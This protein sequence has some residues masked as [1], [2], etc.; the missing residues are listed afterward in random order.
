MKIDP[1]RHKEKYLAWKERVKDGIPEISLENTQI[2]LQYL[3][4]MERGVNIASESSKGS[5]SF[6]RLNTL[7][8]KLLFFSKKFKEIYNLEKIID[9]TEEQVV[10]FFSDMKNGYIKRIDGGTYRSVDTYSK[11]FKSFWHWHQ[12]VNRKKGI[13]LESGKKEVD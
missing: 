4:D 11:A 8:D 7:K 2:I 9:I 5:R 1:Y 6:I 12:K 13:T 10:A 3:N